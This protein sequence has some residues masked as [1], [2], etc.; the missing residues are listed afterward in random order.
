MSTVASVALL[1]LLCPVH[2]ATHHPP[3]GPLV[4]HPL[5]ASPF[6]RAPPF[7]GTKVTVPAVFTTLEQ[8]PHG[9][10]PPSPTREVALSLACDDAPMMTLLMLVPAASDVLESRRGMTTRTSS[11]SEDLSNDTHAVFPLTVTQAEGLFGSVHE[12]HSAA[13]IP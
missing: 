5:L 6:A 8:M 11:G 1:L 10:S 13:V 2:C 7:I 9:R 12:L 3:G 4:P